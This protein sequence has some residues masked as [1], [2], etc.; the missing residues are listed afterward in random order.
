MAESPERLNSGLNPA[1]SS[2][3]LARIYN[4]A[5]LAL[6]VL[7]EAAAAGSPG[8]VKA[9]QAEAE[10]LLIRAGTWTQTLGRGS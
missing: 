2:A 10:R 1:Q 3:P 8:A 9:L 5:V 7:Y 6:D 4:D